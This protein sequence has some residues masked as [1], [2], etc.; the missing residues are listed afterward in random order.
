M[1]NIDVIARFERNNHIVQ[2]N[3]AN[4]HLMRKRAA[5]GDVSIALERRATATANNASLGDCKLLVLSPKE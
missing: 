1:P 2:R 5:I 3:E 4:E